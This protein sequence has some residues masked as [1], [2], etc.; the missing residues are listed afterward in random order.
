[1]W[2]QQEQSSGFLFCIWS[3]E[4]PL[5]CSLYTH[6]AF[7][8][9]T[10]S[11][12]HP[13]HRNRLHQEEKNRLRKEIRGK[14]GVNHVSCVF[15]CSAHKA[16]RDEPGLCCLWFF[17]WDV[18]WPGLGQGQRQ[19][20]HPPKPINRKKAGI[21]LEEQCRPWIKGTRVQIPDLDS[22]ST[23]FVTSTSCLFSLCL[24]IKW[25]W[26]QYTFSH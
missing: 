25:R 8:I 2:C 23:D 16:Q 12:A 15:P 17:L 1:M 10:S 20:N 14:I 11:C 5:H 19:N 4:S 21:S 13:P 9:Q 22:S 26:E 7:W 6:E 18:R 24:G 3:P